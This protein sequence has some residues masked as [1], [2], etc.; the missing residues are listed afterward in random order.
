MFWLWHHYV[1][2][3]LKEADYEA[4]QRTLESIH[5]LPK[6]NGRRVFA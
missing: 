4:F 2:S 5:A 3:D 6:F 1:T